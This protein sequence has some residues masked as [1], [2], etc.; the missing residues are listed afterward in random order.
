MRS[1]RSRLGSGA[2]GALPRALA[3][4]LRRGDEGAARGRPAGPVRGSPRCSSRPPAR[5]R[6][7]SAA[8]AGDLAPAAA[9]RLSVGALFA[10][11]LAHVAR[12]LDVRQADRAHGPGGTWA[13]PPDGGPDRDHGGGDPR[14][15]GDRARRTAARL[16]VAQGG[17][18]AAR[19]KARPAAALARDRGPAAARAR[20]A[21]RAYRTGAP[22]RLPCGLRA[23]AADPGRASACWPAR[24]SRRSRRKRRCVA[25]RHPHGLLRLA[26]WSG[27][28]L[29]LA[30]V[31][32]A[33]GLALYVPALW[34]T[35]TPAWRR[36]VRSASA[37]V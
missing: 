35:G 30:M 21:A 26:A 1:A 9:M 20:G 24:W 4:S 15:G 25:R 28:A 6:A 37:P 36:P 18:A 17:C 34:S 16:A 32:V 27:Q 33:A 29:A 31:L 14:R 19:P 22:R 5:T 12:G 13:Q 8:G 10:C 2:A 7:R 3:R 11:W 23:R